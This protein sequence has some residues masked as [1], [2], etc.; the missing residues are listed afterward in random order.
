MFGLV[1]GVIGML[2]YDGDRVRENGMFQGY[3]SLTCV[4][5]A[6]QVTVTVFQLFI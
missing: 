4:V 5:V 2:M 1:F 6:L 3:N